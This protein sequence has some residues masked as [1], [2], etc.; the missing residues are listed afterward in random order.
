MPPPPHNG[1]FGGPESAHDSVPQP[2]RLVL[3]FDGT[4]NQYMG[5]EEDT[6]IVKIYES[7][8]RHKPGQY[9]YYQRKLTTN[10]TSKRKN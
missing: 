6:N 1:P 3:C 7:L 4:G 5:T 2:R 8:E 10:T 9:A